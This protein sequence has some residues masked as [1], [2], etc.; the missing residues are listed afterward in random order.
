MALIGVV[1]PATVRVV[2][3]IELESGPA[4]A[5]IDAGQLVD[6][7]AATGQWV[8]ASS[9]VARAKGIA[10]TTANAANITIDVLKKGV[11][12]V[13][14]V[15]DAMAYGA[16]VWTAGVA[17]PGRMDDA[18]VDLLAPIGMVVPGQGTVVPDRLLRI[19]C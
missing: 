10:I 12:D 5:A 3:K 13:G 14:S 6:F 16:S 18:V 15:L 11:V 9:N 17:N 7:N 8:L 19:D 1:P 4:G 2:R